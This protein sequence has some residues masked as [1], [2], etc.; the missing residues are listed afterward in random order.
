M[1]GHKT[2]RPLCA[3]S[4]EQWRANVNGRTEA[5]QRT[6]RSYS[7]INDCSEKSRKSRGERNIVRCK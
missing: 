3:L 1:A 7:I 4:I 6:R 5:D 2:I